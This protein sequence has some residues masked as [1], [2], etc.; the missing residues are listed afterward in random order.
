[1]KTLL[2]L[3]RNIL[4]CKRAENEAADSGDNEILQALNGAISLTHVRSALANVEYKNQ[5]RK[6]KIIIT[7]ILS[8]SLLNC[9][10][11]D[12]KTQ[13]ANKPFTLVR[14]PDV[15]M[16]PP[17]GSVITINRAKID[18]FL[19]KAESWEKGIL[20]NFTG[21]KLAYSNDYYFDLGN[22]GFTDQFYK[23]TGIKGFY[24]SKMRFYAYYCYD[25]NNKI[26]TEDE[27]G[28]F[29]GVCFNN[30]FAASLCTDVGVFTIN[31]KYVFRILEKKNSD[32]RIDYYEQLAMSNVNDTVYKSKN[33][34]IILRNS[35]L[36]VF[37][38]VK[39]KEYLEQMLKDIDV[40]KE[41]QKTELTSFYQMQVKQFEDEVKIKKTYDKTY[42]AEKEALERKR[43]LEKWTPE[44]LAKEISKTEAGLNDG[45]AVIQQ[46]LQK[47]QE[48]QDRPIKQFYSGSSY[49]ANGLKE[50]FER[51]DVSALSS[52]QETGTQIVYLNPAYFN[53]SLGAD[54]PQLIM[55]YLPKGN[56]PHMKKLAELIH[57]PGA[58]S[59]LQ[60]ILSPG[61]QTP[62]SP[63]TS[64]SASAYTL[65]Y[66]QKLNKLSPLI[67]PADMKPSVIPIVPAGNPQSSAQLNFE[68][69]VLS[70]KL[71]LLPALPF[72]EDAYIKYLQELY[73]KISGAIN[74]DEKRKADEYL[75]INKLT[76]S[77]NISNAALA[78]WLQN[79][80]KA[81]LY[82]Y[83][84]A[85]SVNSSDALTANNFS[86][87]LIMGG[88]PEKAIPILDYWN[89]QKPGEP[90]ILCNLGNA[91]YRLGDS[92]NAMKYLQQCVQKD[93][94]NPT[95]NKI[96]CIMYL[97]KGDVKKAEENGSR[98]IATCIDD[99]VISI[100]RQLNSK[101]KPGEIMS[102]YPPMPEKQFPMLERIKLPAMPSR[103]DD[104]E[105]FAIE[106][107]AL[108]ESLKMTVAGIEA[109][110]P[111]ANDDLQQ[112]ILISGLKN[113]I[114]AIQVKAQYII[115][116]GMQTYHHD[117]IQEF[118]VFSYHLKKMNISHNT[119]VKGIQNKYN[120]RLKKLEGGEGGGEDAISALELAKCN[121]LNA[122]TEVYLAGFSHLVNQYGER[123]EYVSRKF[124]RDYANW[125]PY[126][127]PETTPFPSIERDY[128][129]DV[130][131]IL[132]EFRVV[133][134]MDCS[135]L[136]PL[137]GKAGTLQKWEE[138]YCANFK[139]KFGIGP[140]KLFWSCSSWGIEAGEAVVGGFE[141]NYAEN[142]EFE[143]ISL[144]LGLGANWS[145]G[146]EHTAKAGAGAAVKEFVK[147][148]PDKIT[149]EWEVSDAGVKGEITIEGEIGNVSGEVKVIEVTAGY[150]SGV[151]KEGF[152]K[153]ILDF[154]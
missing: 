53:K 55:V 147:L 57:Q 83:S 120:E 17:D 32:G 82:L 1:M 85:V 132:D 92:P 67:I 69:P 24:F 154:N 5:C 73:L 87:F 9:Y 146:T 21:A 60:A 133:K 64:S 118:D 14:F 50:Y 137:P 72:T 52:E 138:D 15:I 31:G 131:N 100:L 61:K 28:S 122:E 40:T 2:T 68:T 16:K 36:P 59:P 13:A 88:L 127:M 139:G 116:D 93:S 43:Y 51:L 63:V 58:L 30:V 4:V 19:N 130:I 65:S 107:D 26:Y 148:G 71:K 35:D 81:G 112:K 145:M 95:A 106:L 10:S 101:V 3:I 79:S 129:K 48:W 103:L 8:L 7:F 150:R 104:M 33:E 70:P 54:A 42:T 39:R 62:D 46:Y 124:F 142:G 94:L 80:P 119:K 22:G 75:K 111:K 135:F 109:Q 44:N 126:W 102:N 151:N 66:L 77:R 121:E 108:K 47:P 91:Y 99:Q 45:R 143:D 141:M 84:K 115:M 123:Q 34:F 149:G 6:M 140:A 76:Q 12:C 25:N 56:Y 110:V 90:S 49:K 18:P 152:A 11:Q 27:S 29:L 153:E 97:K 98:S 144:E 38:T 20:K 74:S 78:A 23:A 134:R 37:I 105:Q 41:K 136:E 114:S 86:A 128:L 89:K 117:Q 96:L 113:G 125:S